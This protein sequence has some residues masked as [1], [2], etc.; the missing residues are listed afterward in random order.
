MPFKRILEYSSGSSGIKQLFARAAAGQLSVPRD[1]HAW[2][3]VT[4][5]Q[6]PIEL[7]VASEEFRK[8]QNWGGN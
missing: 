6:R 2:W 8:A 4:R 3:R 1:A 5:G 7:A